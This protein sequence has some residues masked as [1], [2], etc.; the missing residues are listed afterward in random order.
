MEWPGAV[1]NRVAMATIT[2]ESA[3]TP[4]HFVDE[5]LNTPG[6]PESE[7]V[8][9]FSKTEQLPGATIP[10]GYTFDSDPET[11]ILQEQ[12]PPADHGRAAWTHLAAAWLVDAISWGNFSPF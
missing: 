4:P 6:S 5:K 8:F 7:R 1:R 9:G 3:P 2:I 12:L 11:P 10:D